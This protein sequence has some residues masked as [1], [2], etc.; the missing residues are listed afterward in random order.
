MIKLSNTFYLV[1]LAAL[2]VLLV[3]CQ[4]DVPE[5]DL[6]LGATTTEVGGV[7]NYSLSIEAVESIARFQVEATIGGSTIYKYISTPN[8]SSVQQDTS[9]FVGQQAGDLIV[10]ARV[11][12]SSGQSVS[13]TEVVQVVGASTGSLNLNWQL[14]YDKEP[15]VFFTPYPYDGYEITF[16]RYTTY[17]S[18][19]DLGQ[20][21][22]DD[23]VFYATIGDA[24]TDATSAAAGYTLS[25]P[26]SPGTYGGFDIA[27]GID[28]VTNSTM[29]RDWPSGHPL[30]SSAEY[31][32]SWRS[33]VFTKIEGTVDTDMD[34]TVDG[35]FALHLGG[36]IA[37]Q[38]IGTET[39][40]TISENNA[41]TA[42]ILFD[43]KDWFYNVED[44]P[45][46]LLEEGSIHSTTHIP[47]IEK[48]Q[49]DYQDQF[50]ISI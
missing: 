33:Y 46:N 25:I 10:V 14:Q 8:A 4:E 40:F 27:M 34:G 39:S 13:D 42:Q 49:V 3:G 43:I 47:L 21:Q 17:L 31:W 38:K 2:A 19:L 7:V 15:L 44:G 32:L 45:Y 30:A 1:S 16:T 20:G 37:Y 28:S 36:D 6:R 35:S 29:P 23:R 41:T 9:F 24:H 22:A 12:D 18:N 48:L 5:V 11:S 26:V 50:T